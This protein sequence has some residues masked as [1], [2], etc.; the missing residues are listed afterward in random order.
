MEARIFGD[1]EV[2]EVGVDAL[3]QGWQRWGETGR[4][5]GDE[6]PA[7]EPHWQQPERELAFS[8]RTLPSAVFGRVFALSDWLTELGLDRRLI[9]YPNLGE[10]KLAVSGDAGRM[11]LLWERIAAA[12]VAGDLIYRVEN[13]PPAPASELPLWSG[14]PGLLRLLSRLKGAFDPEGTLRP[15]AYSIT[16]LERAAEFFEAGGAA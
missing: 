4:R 8:L 9:A 5:P 2:V 11:L 1:R 13:Q 15:G 3:M 12:A 6:L 7:A 16:E 14:Q 10:I